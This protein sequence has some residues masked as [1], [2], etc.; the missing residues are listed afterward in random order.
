LQNVEQ[1]EQSRGVKLAK[2]AGELVSA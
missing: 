2:G 1:V